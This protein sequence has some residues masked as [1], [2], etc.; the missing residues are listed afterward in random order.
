[1]ALSKKNKT[2]SSFLAFFLA[3]GII[4]LI[5]SNLSFSLDLT[6]EK[7]FTLSP[8]SVELL[9]KLESPA[10]IRVYLGGNMPIDFKRFKESIKA[11]LTEYKRIAGKNIQF[12][13]INPTEN[14]NKEERFALYQYLYKNG[15]TP[16]E[17]KEEGIEQSSETM[18]FPAAI[19]SYNNKELGV[20]LLQSDYRFSPESPENI[21]QSAQALEYE[22]TNALRK[23]MRKKTEKIAFVEG[24]GELSEVELASISRT[25]AEYYQIDRGSLAGQLD[26]LNDY[27]ALIIASP[28]YKFTNEEKYVLD[29]YIMQ[30]G[31]VLFMLEG[32]N[33]RMDSLNTQST[34]LAIPASVN[35]EDLL[36]KYGLRINAD[37]VEDLRCSKIGLSTHGYNNK[38]EIKWFPW[39]YFPMLVSENN[40]PINKYIDLIR[41]E[42]ISTIDT[43]NKTEGL[44]K[45]I[46]L[47]SSTSSRIS[48]TPLPI[49]FLNINI[50]A[51]KNTFNHKP[52]PVAVLL[53]GS[54]TSLYKTRIVPIEKLGYK[55][56]EN[57]KKTKII[58]ISDGDM[59]RNIISPE[60]KPYPLGFDRYSQQTFKGNT[61]FLLN[62]INYLIEDE[63]VMTTRNR[64]IK[65]RPLNKKKIKREKT[66]WQLI[67][68][69]LPFIIL[70]LGGILFN[71]LRKQKYSQ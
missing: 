66:K 70:I 19:I 55:K 56:I 37:I 30:G 36:F 61:Q 10:V 28:L 48:A 63:S 11:Q 24:H 49:S 2:I 38:T 29:Q 23:I 68:V 34:T 57:S 14:P 41:T 33:I 8:A 9:E 7:R 12:V 60:G 31:S 42:F 40:H 35:L 3:L 39:H 6:E 20:N 53:E 69:L 51:D 17:A 26:Q 67:N 27:K 58:V 54:F 65:H 50:P 4:N 46:L 1:M 43:V 45:T 13:F 25:L 15:I 71:I 59:I 64:E 18:L 21:N 47:S 22:F 52:L 32:V 16:I 62:S 5:I 44:K